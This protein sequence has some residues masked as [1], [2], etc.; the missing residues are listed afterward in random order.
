MTLSEC[1]D[2]YINDNKIYLKERTIINY[3][4]REKHLIKEFGDINIE[5]I[6]QEY[7]QNYIN[8][9]EKKGKSKNTIKNTLVLLLISLKPYK[10][11]GKFRYMNDTK[12]KEIY[13]IED[14]EKIEKYI[15]LNDKDTYMPIMIAIN[16]GMRLSEI[17]G[18]KWKDI[19]FENRT[20]NVGRNLIHLKGKEI[21]SLPKTKNGKRQ[22]PINDNLYNYLKD[23]ICDDKEYYVITN[24]EIS[25]NQRGIQKTNQTLCDKLGIK[26]CGMHA[27]RHAF[28]SRLLKTSQDFKSI[29]QI[30]G[31]SNIAITQNIYNHPTNE[32]KQ[33]VINS[34]FGKTEPIYSQINYQPQI[35]YLQNQINDLRVVISRLIQYV[36]D[37][38]EK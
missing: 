12:D 33:N 15:L 3:K 4:E 28:A 19:D 34:A 13:S 10:N 21:V 16:T 9:M 24:K 23:K 7:L 8:D 5:I 30:M 37:T 6:T 36:Q 17:L 26:N 38:Q 31:H 29:S 35:E 1:I 20:I 32:Q 18:L 14:I 27:Y 11:F 22:I 25:K 2:K